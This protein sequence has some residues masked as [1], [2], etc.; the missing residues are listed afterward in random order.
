MQDFIIEP[1]SSL[2][3]V[4]RQDC[5]FNLL[6]S[7]GIS[8]KYQS[9]SFFSHFRLKYNPY[10][11][12]FK[13]YANSKSFQF[14]ARFICLFVCTYFYLNEMQHMQ[15]CRMTSLCNR[16]STQLTERVS[17]ES[18]CAASYWTDSN[19]DTHR[20]AASPGHMRPRLESSDVSVADW[21]KFV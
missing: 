2:S 7:N 13:F 3:G 19:T 18:F 9:K 17:F 1:R 21:D 4:T 6:I 20:H 5:G 11:T 12:T 8:K 16:E 10:T 15:W 14:P